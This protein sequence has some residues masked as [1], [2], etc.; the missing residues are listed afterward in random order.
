MQGEKLKIQKLIVIALGIGCSVGA[1][2][3]TYDYEFQLTA[4]SSNPL[5]PGTVSGTIHYDSS[6]AYL[7]WAFRVMTINDTTNPYGGTQLFDAGGNLIFEGNG[8]NRI[9]G[10]S[11]TQDV[12][13]CLYNLDPTDPQSTSFEILYMP[14]DN[15]GSLPAVGKTVNVSQTILYAQDSSG[16]IGGSGQYYT[17]TITNI[18][19]VPEPTP[20]LGVAGLTMGAILLRKKA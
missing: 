11:P 13:E 19:A 14:V 17:G 3:T 15:Q 8:N 1:F 10:T 16:A 5:L 9:L 12:L 18:S 20:L 4:T 7:G 2:A 6:T